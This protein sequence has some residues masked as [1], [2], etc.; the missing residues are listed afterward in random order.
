MTQWIPVGDDFIV[1]D[2][3]RWSEGVFK[4]R[5]SK[6]GRAVKLGE[7]VVIAEVLRDEAGWV[8][9]LVRSCEVVAAR[10]GRTVS[11][12]PVLPKDTTMKRKRATISRG[13]AERLAWSDESARAVLASRFLGNS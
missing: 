12:V 10:I 2:M 7:R 9:L 3:I 13:K 4:N 8:A 1:A 6:K 5:Q 11:E